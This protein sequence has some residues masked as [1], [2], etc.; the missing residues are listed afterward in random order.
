[1]SAPTERFTQTVENYQKYRPGY[2][3]EI[4]IPLREQCGLNKES[5]I[6]DIGSGTGFLTKLFLENDNEVY[7]VE[8]NVAMRAMAEENLKDFKKFH[9]IAA[10]AEKTTLADNSIDC[11]VAGTAFHWF[12]ATAAQKE[13]KRILKSPGYVALI[14][15][16]RAVEK[17]QVMA[18][19]ETLIE[20]YARD[21]KNTGAEK[22]DKT[23]VEGFFSPYQMHY[24]SIA[25]KQIFD[26][27]GLQGR[28]LSSSYSLRSDDA[29]YSEMIAA[30][31]R[32]FDRHQVNN[33][34][35]FV[36]EAKMYFGQ[37]N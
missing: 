26:W 4:L 31:K 2:P 29:K 1:M 14:W 12:D 9:S 36:Y 11:I 7:G 37:L 18:D 6:A 22:F 30:L 35:E 20:D 8:P 32:I 17:S 19:Y 33:Q 27:E 3:H 16:V 5:I 24:Y 28:L 25:N 23:A 15:N 10:T 21:Y 34:I 13:F